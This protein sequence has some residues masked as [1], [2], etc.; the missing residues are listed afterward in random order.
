MSS[1][2]CRMNSGP[3]RISPEPTGSPTASW[4]KSTPVSN[5]QRSGLRIKTPE[6][7]GSM[8]DPSLAYRPSIRKELTKSFH[9]HRVALAE[10]LFQGVQDSM[11]QPGPQKLAQLEEW[12]RA[13]FL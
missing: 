3:C 2:R 11:G 10:A 7:L 6:V 1:T 8:Y 9:L 12:P 13:H 4:E 5:A